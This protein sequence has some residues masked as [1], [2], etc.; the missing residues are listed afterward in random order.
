[1]LFDTIQPDTRLGGA[2]TRCPTTACPMGWPGLLRT[3]LTNVVNT[4]ANGQSVC[5]QRREGAGSASQPGH[6][7]LARPDG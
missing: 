7:R 3:V 5:A 1:V 2:V 4:L 6:F